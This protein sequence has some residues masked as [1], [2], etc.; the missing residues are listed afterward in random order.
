MYRIIVDL[1]HDISTLSL[2]LREKQHV[3]DQASYQRAMQLFYMTLKKTYEELEDVYFHYVLQP[4][5]RLLS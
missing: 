4:E 2:H 3:K 1:L 5:M